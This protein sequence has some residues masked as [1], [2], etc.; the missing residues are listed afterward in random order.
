MKL[1]HIY[2]T[3]FFVLSI[4]SLPAQ[5]KP[6]SLKECIK[7]A[8]ANKSNIL[9]LK[10]DA[11]IDSLNIKQIRAQNLPQIAFA[12]DY[13]YNPIIRTNI[14]PVGQFSPVPSDVTRAIQFGTKFNQTAGLHVMQPLFDA[15]I[16]SRIKESKLQFRLRQDEIKTANEE[17]IFEVAQ[18]FI[19]ILTKQEQLKISK[20]D[21]LRTSK[22][23][24]LAQNRFDKGSILKMELNKARINHNNAV[25]AFT[26]TIAALVI[27]K[28][29]L[30]FLTNIQFTTFEIADVDQVFNEQNL[31]FITQPVKVEN[32]AKINAVDSKISLVQQQIKSEKVKYLPKLSFNGYL[33][34]D[35]F[36]NNLQP[37]ESN[38]WFGN[39]FVGVG[40]KLPV[41]IGE[42]KS[43]KIGQFKSQIKSL[44]YQKQDELNLTERNRQTA[45]QEIAVLQSQVKNYSKNIELL[46]ENIV[47]FNERLQAGQE[48]FNNINLEEI[49][50]QKEIQK[51]NTIKKD[52]WQQWLLFIKNAGM[53]EK[54]SI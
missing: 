13:L 5:N 1:K 14:V 51:L 44:E 3:A 54:I 9:A 40:L 18:L 11:S 25:F 53:L 35:Q 48:S 24:E 7:F 41:L 8:L 30:S 16:R 28:I 36:S 32:I 10:A 34:A 12:Y 39:S 38:T 19:S 22:T 4:L 21:T 52:I 42:N 49:D 20:L 47:L 6:L 27:D 46:K 29:Y 15:S 37:F 23:L 17:L 50:Y 33:G 43:N 45:M 2:I 26:E 31:N